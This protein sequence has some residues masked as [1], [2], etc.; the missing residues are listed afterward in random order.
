M[1]PTIAEAQNSPPNLDLLAV[2]RRF[3]SDSKRLRG[4]RAVG[5]LV[6]AIPL[7]VLAALAPTTQTAVT[8]AS[9]FWLLLALVLMIGLERRRTEDGTKVLEEFDVAVF[10]LEWNERVAGKRV[11]PERIASVL[12]RCG[13]DR[14]RLKNWYPSVTDQLPW[15][16]S[17]L[18]CQ[19]AAVVWDWRLRRVYGWFAVT[20]TLALLGVSVGAAVLL[21]Y[22]TLQWLLLLALPMAA[23]FAGGAEVASAS[24]SDAREQSEMHDRLEQDWRRALQDPASTTP[25]ECRQHQDCRFMHR[26]RANPIPDWWY[27]AWRDRYEADMCHA[28][29]AMVRQFTSQVTVESPGTE[30]S[31]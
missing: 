3:Y 14:A 16:V 7:P 27:R 1:C 4:I 12:R 15:P 20:L 21:G 30:A 9:G 25:A 5:S 28:A 31:L 23:A 19:R 24:L 26:L 8:A 11:V 22:S 6:A 18:V 10:G 13:A 17:V 29:E 2:Q